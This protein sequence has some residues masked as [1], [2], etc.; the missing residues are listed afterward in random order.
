MESA[1]PTASASTNR[2]GRPKDWT[3]ARIRRYIRLYLFTRLS[4]EDI[5]KLLEED[6]FKPGKDAANKVKNSVLGNDPRWLRPRSEEEE[7]SRIR[8][9]R[10]GPFGRRCKP[11]STFPRTNTTAA[12]NP[13]AGS[14]RGFQD[15]RS[16]GGTTLADSH[17]ES[18]FEFT[19]TLDDDV[20][21]S[22]FIPNSIHQLGVS[23]HSTS[24]TTSTD[25]SITSSW[26]ER[27]AFLP[28]NT[29]KRTFTVLKRYTFPK[30]LEFQRPSDISSSPFPGPGLHPVIYHMNDSSN[31]AYALPGDFLN[32]GILNRWQQ[33][34]VDS[35]A[36]LAGVCW[37]KIA[38][39]VSTQSPWANLRMPFHISD[40][41]FMTKDTFG[42]TIFHR[43]A[44]MDGTQDFFLRLLPQ[45]LRIPTRPLHD[46]NTAGQTFLHVLHRS[47]FQ[48]GSRLDEL[49]DVLQRSNFDLFATDVY[50]RSFYHLL[51]ANK[52]SINRFP[53]TISIHRMNRRDA[54]GIQ[55]VES[56]SSPTAG[57]YATQNAR[58]SRTSTTSSK[59]LP[60]INTQT[61]VVRE[62][63]FTSHANLLRVILR[64]LEPDH[65]GFPSAQFED[66][67]GRNGFHAVAEVD[68][69]LA[70]RIPQSGARGHLTNTPQPQ[71][72]TQSK[73]KYDEDEEVDPPRT[74]SGSL[75][76]ESIWSLIHAQVDVNQYD[77]QGNTPLMSFV[78]NSSD[79]TRHDKEE[80]EAVIRALVKDAHANIE[81]RNRSGETALHL[82][83]RYGKIIALR[84]LLGLGANPHARNCQGLSILQVVS[85]LYLATE[86]DDKN[87]GRFQACLA[88]LTSTTEYTADGP[89]LRQEWGL[90]RE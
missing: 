72:K 15:N 29:V 89:T 4:K 87:N 90:E 16:L 43:L 9:L 68:F 71:L 39:Q 8:G 1:S 82:A 49:I 27:L 10:N 57:S 17:R 63:D 66:P 38:Q 65:S 18:S 69:G 42:N 44:S 37:C 24:L 45:V 25:T 56:E 61:Q 84:A 73:R 64:A 3:V 83:A 78:V 31:A 81:S 32:D 58:I 54:F 35:P 52:R 59:L 22:H 12:D 62:R 48:A 47:W 2:G 13:S 40:S 76:L 85:R 19:A 23:R 60:S 75:R 34:V 7:R 74:A 41:D 20:G 28:L 21:A 86:R 14:F 33:C 26:R 53:A 46:S 11:G 36:H 30:D 5:L 55:L 50:G 6:E 67:Q 70:S 88:I 79:A 51:L 80:T 77:K